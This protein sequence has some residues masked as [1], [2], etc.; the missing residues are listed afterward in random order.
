[1]AAMR[2]TMGPKAKAAGWRSVSAAFGFLPWMNRDAED[3]Y[4]T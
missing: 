3:T 2:P 1:M 4:Q